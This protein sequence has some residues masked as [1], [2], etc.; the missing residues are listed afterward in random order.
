MKTVSQNDPWDIVCWPLHWTVLSSHGYSVSH[1]F[2]MFVSCFSKIPLIFLDSN[3]LHIFAVTFIF[4]LYTYLRIC[5]SIF[6]I[7]N[8]PPSF[9]LPPLLSFLG[10]LSFPSQVLLTSLLLWVHS[11]NPQQVHFISCQN[12]FQLGK[13]IVCSYAI[14][15]SPSC[16]V[17]YFFHLLG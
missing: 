14:H 5:T 1:V 16:L 13:S 15:M 8:Q 17:S 6:G 2:K 9:S 4:I 11:A 12:G 7:I 10:S 3:P